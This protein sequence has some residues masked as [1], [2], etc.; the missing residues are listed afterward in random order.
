MFKNKNKYRA[1]LIW[2]VWILVVGIF[3]FSSH[4]IEKFHGD[5]FA[6]T[7]YVYKSGCWFIF[8][9]CYLF[10]LTIQGQLLSGLVQCSAIN[11]CYKINCGLRCLSISLLSGLLFQDFLFMIFSYFIGFSYSVTSWTE[12]TIIGQEANCLLLWRSLGSWK[13]ASGPHLSFLLFLMPNF[14]RIK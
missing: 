8:L 4:K 12:L 9:F 13:D 11:D 7:I 1:F 2:E 6:S 14:W 3:V 10:G 5:E